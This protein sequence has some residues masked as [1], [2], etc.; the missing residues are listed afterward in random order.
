M[1]TKT[2]LFF[3]L[4]LY[5]LIVLCL[6]FAFW[7]QMSLGQKLI[8][9]ST[10]PAALLVFTDVIQRERA[11]KDVELKAI[12][13]GIFICMLSFSMQLLTGE[14]SILIITWLGITLCAAGVGMKLVR[15]A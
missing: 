3:V 4:G 13:A 7:S 8:L 12:F 1:N 10:L 9:G 15:L 6:G 11:T 2:R 14:L 5:G